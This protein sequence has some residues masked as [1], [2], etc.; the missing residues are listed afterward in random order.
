[1]Q[2]T[3]KMTQSLLKIL[4]ICYFRAFGQAHRCLTTPNNNYMIKQAKNGLFISNNFEI[5]KF[6]NMQ[7]DLLRAF[8][9]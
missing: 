1:M 7:S 5:F 8:Y 3:N 4:A 9:A 2:K 6:K